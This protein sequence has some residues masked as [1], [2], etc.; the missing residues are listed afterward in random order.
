MS[1]SVGVFNVIY[2]CYKINEHHHTHLPEVYHDGGFNCNIMFYFSIM[3][4]SRQIK[5]FVRK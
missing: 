4:F 2:L 5:C 3:G 1:A